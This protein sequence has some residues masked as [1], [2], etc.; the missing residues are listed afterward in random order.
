MTGQ[1]P[2]QTEFFFLFFFLVIPFNLL[3]IAA[4]ILHSGLNVYA[5]N[6]Q[7]NKLY[8]IALVTVVCMHNLGHVVWFFLNLKPTNRNSNNIF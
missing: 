7:I 5:L 8:S 3:V 4:V 2:R 1:T 6:N